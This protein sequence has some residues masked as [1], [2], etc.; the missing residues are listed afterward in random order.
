MMSSIYRYAHRLLN[1]SSFHKLS[2][3]KSK[4]L[5]NFAHFFLINSEEEFMF[6]G[7]SRVIKIFDKFKWQK[8]IRDFGV[9]Y[10]CSGGWCCTYI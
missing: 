3:T 6:T 8:L 7:Y 10:P 5:L 4:K 1:A 2:K 9:K